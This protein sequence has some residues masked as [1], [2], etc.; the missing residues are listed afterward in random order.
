MHG[1]STK[2]WKRTKKSW[3]SRQALIGWLG[4]TNR[5]LDWNSKRINGPSYDVRSTIEAK[6]KKQV[7]QPIAHGVCLPASCSNKKIFQFLGSFLETADVRVIGA[8][9]TNMNRSV[10]LILHPRMWKIVLFMPSFEIIFQDSSS[11]PRASPD[12]QHKLRLVQTWLDGRAKSP[13]DCLLRL[14]KRTT[15]FQAFYCKYDSMF[16]W[17]PSAVNFLD[18]FVTPFA[19]WRSAKQLY[20]VSPLLVFLLWKFAWKGLLV[21]SALIAGSSIYVAQICLQS[22]AIENSYLHHLFSFSTHA[23]LGPWIIGILLWYLFHRLRDVECKIGKKLNFLLWSLWVLW[24]LTFMW[25]A[26]YFSVFLIRTGE[27]VELLDNAIFMGVRRQLWALRVARIIF[28]CQKLET[29]GFIRWLLCLNF[30]QPISKLSLSIYVT[31]VAYVE[32][33]VAQREDI[34]DF[35]L[36]NYVSPL[37]WTDGEN[38]FYQPIFQLHSVLGDIMAMLLIGCLVSLTFEGSIQEIE[39]YFMKSRQNKVFEVTKEEFE[40]VTETT[41]CWIKEMIIYMF[42]ISF[43]FLEKLLTRCLRFF[44]LHI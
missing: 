2:K 14:L 17:Y 27:H 4:A 35:E 33:L 3:N 11:S 28:A 29:G 19:N 7:K 39:K 40:G 6:V 23:R 9:C 36:S 10:Q 42:H 32:I 13:S 18:N 8:Q 24:T 21:L 38:Y 16:V 26:V 12:L 44:T 20:A 31:H 43:L 41:N 34:I 22:A 30:W 15:I 25:L 1:L 5:K 37:N